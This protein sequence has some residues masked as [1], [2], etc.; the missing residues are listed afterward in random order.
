MPYFK[1]ASDFAIPNGNFSTVGGDQRN[2]VTKGT[3]KFQAA[4]T[5]KEGVYDDNY[6]EGA[7]HFTA[8]GGN[9]SSVRGNQDNTY[10]GTWK[11]SNTAAP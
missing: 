9:F 8:P 6:F 11:T 4:S 1:K 3:P 7:K 5:K 10:E 2:N